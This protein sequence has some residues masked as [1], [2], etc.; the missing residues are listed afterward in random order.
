MYTL[1]NSEFYEKSLQRRKDMPVEGN[2]KETVFTFPS[3]Q[4][5]NITC[6]SG[7][8]IVQFVLQNITVNGW[9]L[10]LKCF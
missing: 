10:I 9:L 5:I 2:F 4:L 1:F 3:L 7:E 6:A 8:I